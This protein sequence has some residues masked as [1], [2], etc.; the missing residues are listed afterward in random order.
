MRLT[1][2]GIHRVELVL[3]CE[4]LLQ[5]L[6]MLSRF[7]GAPC[8]RLRLSLAARLGRGAGD[9]HASCAVDSTGA[10]SW[11][12]ASSS[13]KGFS[14]ADHSTANSTRA[15]QHRL[16]ADETSLALGFAAEAWYV[17]R[18]TDER[19][20]GVN[21]RMILRTVKPASF[22][23]YLDVEYS[24][25]AKGSVDGRSFDEAERKAILRKFPHSV[26]LELAFPE[27]DF[28][29]R[30][31]WRQFGPS[32]GD[33]HQKSSDYCFCDIIDPHSH[34]GRWRTHWWVKTEYNFGFNEWFFASAA[35][36]DQFLEFVPQI[37]WGELYPK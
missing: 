19:C 4:P 27:L 10:P 17:G 12:S 9:W 32:D 18:T 23:H 35:D 26:V 34:A 3:N 1:P 5:R 16:A 37:C 6:P 24:V 22:E 13:W 20:L 30:W 8:H 11:P 36:R 33:C 28:A 21:A 25:A 15:A 29:N 14:F 31:C 2:A 7:A